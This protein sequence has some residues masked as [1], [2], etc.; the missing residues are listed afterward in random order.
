M[1]RPSDFTEE[2]HA[3]MEREFVKNTSPTVIA[4]LPGMEGS[5]GPKIKYWQDLFWAKFKLPSQNARFVGVM[6]E[7]G[8]EQV[9]KGLDLLF[10]P[11]K[12]ARE[13]GFNGSLPGTMFVKID[14]DGDM[15]I[16]STAFASVLV[17]GES[18]MRPRV[19]SATMKTCKPEVTGLRLTGERGIDSA[20]V[21]IVESEELFRRWL[22]GIIDGTRD[23][24]DDLRADVNVDPKI[25]TARLK[26]QQMKKLEADMAEIHEQMAA[27]RTGENHE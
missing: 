14:E 4:Q 13:S 22:R 20:L 11:I 25:L 24:F 17:K 16:S 7:I 9:E 5:Y 6:Q 3:I 10:E 19:F 27:R 18:R 26:E 23:M 8:W 15:L 1:G 21:F 2:Q 12:K